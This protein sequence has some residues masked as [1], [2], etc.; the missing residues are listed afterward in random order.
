MQSRQTTPRMPTWAR[1]LS[2]P[3]LLAAGE[4][5]DAI[6]V[7]AD[8][9][10]RAVRFLEAS[11]APVGPVLHDLC[12]SRAYFLTAPGTA[13]A[14]RQSGTQ[15]LGPGSWVVLAP[16]GWDWLLRWVSEPTDGPA[17]TAAD[18][19]TTALAVAARLVECEEAGR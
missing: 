12:S 17:F 14:W 13:G 4:H 19:L 10:V 16:P 8:V 9:G 3:Q 7:E 5:W 6:R 11:G 1:N 2:Q 15:A 18:D